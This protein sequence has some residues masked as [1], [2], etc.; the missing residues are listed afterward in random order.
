MTIDVEVVCKHL[1]HAKEWTSIQLP[2]MAK[3]RNRLFST[4]RRADATTTTL[5]AANN[6]AWQKHDSMPI[7]I[8]P[9]T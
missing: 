3:K 6:N 4:K 8:K 5:S 7:A 2:T 9:K 1:Q